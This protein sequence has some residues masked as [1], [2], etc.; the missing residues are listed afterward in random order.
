MLRMQL[1]PHFM[2]NSLNVISSLFL[3][4]RGEE[5]QRM[6]DK[7]AGF[8]RAATAI[9]V[10]SNQ[11]GDELEL[12]ESYLEVEGARFGERLN[13][14]VEYSDEVEEAL[15]PAFLLQPLIENALKYGVQRK[16]GRVEVRVRAYR[17]EASLILSVEDEAEYSS[18]VHPG[19]GGGVGLVNIRTR[20]EL[21]F[22]REAELVTEQRER[23]YR[24]TV[25]LP[26]RFAIS[27]EQIPSQPALQKAE[28]AN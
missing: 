17:S 11:V 14:L 18:L 4:G 12:M 3:D 6:T 24:A 22:G 28:M 2:C 20:L 7:L 21:L 10:G 5:A 9:E 26:L 19:S 27:N 23:G 15:M 8:L 1:N 16:G 13:I 25:R